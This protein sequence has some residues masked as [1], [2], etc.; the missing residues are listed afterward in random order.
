[1]AS[2]RTTLLDIDLHILAV[3]SR[4]YRTAASNDGPRGY[5]RGGPRPA[6]PSYNFLNEGIGRLWQDCQMVY[7]R[8]VLDSGAVRVERVSPG[9]SEDADNQKRERHG[10]IPVDEALVREIRVWS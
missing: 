3:R 9:R 10:W 2:T 1:M 6:V 4:N 8:L 5:A 7:D